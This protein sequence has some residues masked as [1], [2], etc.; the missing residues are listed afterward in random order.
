M[1]TVLL[2]LLFNISNF[3]TQHE[4]KDTYEVYKITVTEDG[5]H[6]FFIKN[7]KDTGLIVMDNDSLKIDSSF[8]EIKPNGKYLFVLEKDEKS[9]RGQQPKGYMVILN[10]GKTQKIWDV[11]KDG[12]MP[13]I[14]TAKNV[15]GKFIKESL[16]QN[17]E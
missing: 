1:K 12:D 7:A 10:S 17:K 2:I 11:T 13:S 4:I 14:Y 5:D 6:I 9:Y 16:E 3:C 8:K 15:N